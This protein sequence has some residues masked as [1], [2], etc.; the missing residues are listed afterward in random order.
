MLQKLLSFL[1]FLNSLEN[2]L[3]AMIFHIYNSCMEFISLV[4]WVS[5][6]CSLFSICFMVFELD[7]MPMVSMRES[8][9]LRVIIIF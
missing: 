5:I 9:S 8:S 7:R 1:C 6:S 3:V 4:F 2:V